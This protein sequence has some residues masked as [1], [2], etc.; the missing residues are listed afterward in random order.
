M[1][2]TVLPPWLQV[3]VA[4][5]AIEGFVLSVWTAVGRQSP[6]D[7][8]VPVFGLSEPKLPA[9]AQPAFLAEGVDH[10]TADRRPSVGLRK[11]YAR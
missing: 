1:T 6:A 10:R 2:R 4:C 8:V 5:A 7:G 3:L 9:D 11:C